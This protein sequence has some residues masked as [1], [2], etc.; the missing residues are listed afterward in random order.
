MAGSREECKYDSCSVEASK[1]WGMCLRMKSFLTNSSCEGCFQRGSPSSLLPSEEADFMSERRLSCATSTPGS[2]GRHCFPLRRC[3]IWLE[4]GLKKSWS[5]PSRGTNWR[6]KATACMGD[7][8]GSSCDSNKTNSSVKGCTQFLCPA[9]RMKDE[10]VHWELPSYSFPLLQQRER[11][12]PPWATGSMGCHCWR[13]HGRMASQSLPEQW[14]ESHSFSK[15]G[16]RKL[17]GAEDPVGVKQWKIDVRFT[18]K[19]I[20]FFN[21]HSF[22]HFMHRVVY[23]YFCDMLNLFCNAPLQEGVLQDQEGEEMPGQALWLPHQVCTAHWEDRNHVSWQT[24]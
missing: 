1:D 21:W 15:V 2:V 17:A 16:R 14:I 4:T 19:R 22:I 5:S 24:S 10:R 8:P 12:S 18:G 11:V 20:K 3:R 7:T 9:C 23:I 13:P 6:K